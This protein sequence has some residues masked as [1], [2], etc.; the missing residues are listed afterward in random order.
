MSNLKRFGKFLLIFLIFLF[1]FQITI[2]AIPAS[3]HYELRS[4]GF[5]AG[6]IIDGQ[7]AKYKMEGIAGEQSGS[8]S[9]SENFKTGP[10]VIFTQQ[11]NVPPA[12]SWT[13]PGSTYD[14]LKI[15]INTGGN[16]SDAKF[17]VAITDNGWGTTYYLQSDFTIGTALG[18]EDFM[19]YADFNTNQGK[20]IT[21]LRSST[22]YRV[23][24]KAQTGNFTESAWGPDVEASTIAPSLTFSV[25]ADSIKFDQLNGENSWT[26]DTKFTS[27]TTSTNAYNGYTVLAYETQPLTDNFNNT[28]NDFGSLN[29]APTIWTDT[30]FGYTTN[31]N[32]L[33]GGTADRFTNGGPK[34]AGFTLDPPGDPVADHLTPVVDTPIS[35]EQFNISYR[36][37]SSQNKKAGIY[38]NTIIYIAVPEY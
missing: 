17:A 29:S 24:V 14:R 10:G 19:T 36:V 35:N 34:Y 1:G 18:P 16:P 5:G 38:Q 27:V 28:I 21:G 32:N 3:D 33:G 22:P 4:Y 2:W 30:G 11:A 7:S 15:I 9:A 23:K 6:G 8:Q 26:D 20:Y 13:N 31:D 12:P 25:S 37:T